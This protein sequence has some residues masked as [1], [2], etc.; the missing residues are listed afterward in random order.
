M[1]TFF[2]SDLHFGHRN[3]IPYCNRPFEDVDKMNEG[4]VAQWNSQVTVE[5]TVYVLGDFSLNA[6]AARAFVPRLNGNKILI[7]GNHD[8]PF[9]SPKNKKAKKMRLRYLEDGWK[10]IHLQLKVTLKNDF[11]QEVLLAHLP[12]ANEASLQYDKRY[13]EFRPVNHGLVL[14][15]GHL[16][17]RY[18]K[19][20]RMLDVGV[21]AHE[22]KL[23]TEAD[24][25]ELINDPREFI[26]SS[27]TEFYKTRVDDRNN[28]AG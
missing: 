20:G 19:L 15:H 16:H 25:I 10:E 11:N 1:N 9:P 7:L 21:D 18:K 12:Y 24:V 3:S 4:L 26:P 8:A 17:G 5:D 14:L 13:L 2:T 6:N 27:I 28:M 23:L 22:M